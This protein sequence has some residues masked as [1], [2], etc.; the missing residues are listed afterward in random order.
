M[1]EHSPEALREYEQAKFELAEILRVISGQRA[2]TGGSAQPAFG[3]DEI[4][5]LF[6]RLAEDRFVLRV[7]GCFSR[8]K[9][10]LMNAILGLDRLPTGIL[11]LTSVITSV[12]YGRP[13]ARNSSRNGAA[14]PSTFPWRRSPIT[15]RSAAIRATRAEFT[16]RTSRCPRRFSAA[17]STSSTVRGWARPFRRTPEPPN[18]ISPK[19]T[20]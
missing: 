16:S 18:H 19:R 15:S 5:D 3:E 4:A 9:T 14:F 12:A 8:G 2:A 6:T 10:S 11:P 1:L 17:A 13:S 20:P 7:A